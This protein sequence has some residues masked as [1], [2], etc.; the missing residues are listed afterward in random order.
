MDVFHDQDSPTVGGRPRTKAYVHA[1]HLGS[2]LRPSR[3]SLLHSS[4]QNKLQ[5]EP[6]Q[7][8]KKSALP[9]W[10]ETATPLASFCNLPETQESSTHS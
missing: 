3:A 8:L 6:M 9:Q 7:G 1:T 10:E 2:S 5:E 4:I